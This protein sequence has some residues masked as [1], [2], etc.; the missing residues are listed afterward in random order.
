MIV[1]GEIA[2]LRTRGTNSMIMIKRL[3]LKLWTFTRDGTLKHQDKKSL[4]NF[5]G[6]HYHPNI[7]TNRSNR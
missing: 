1:I 7:P 3:K 5:V 6:Q 4:L 2:Q